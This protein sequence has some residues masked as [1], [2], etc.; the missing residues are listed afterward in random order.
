MIVALSESFS[1]FSS[2]VVEEIFTFLLSLSTFFTVPVISLLAVADDPDGLV[3][4]VLDDDWLDGLWV[5]D[6]DLS[7]VL[8]LVLDEDGLDWLD[9]LW[10]GLGGVAEEAPPAP[11]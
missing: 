4:A 2:P 11:D 6:E 9:E 1:S 5:A 8:E 7:V 3:E 10:P